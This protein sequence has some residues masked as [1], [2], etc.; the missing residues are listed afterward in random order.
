[1][2]QNSYSFVDTAIDVIQAIGQ[3]KARRDLDIDSTT[4]DGYV[5]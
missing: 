1:M 3:F 4:T 2:K 5:Q